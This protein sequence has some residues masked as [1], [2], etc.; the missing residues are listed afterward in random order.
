LR[1]PLLVLAFCLSAC[2][3]RG[4]LT[5]YPQAATVGK[6]ETIFVAS[7]RDFDPALGTYGT[8]RAETVTFSRFE[9]SI[10][11]VR[12]VGEIAWPKKDQTPDPETEFFT[13]SAVSF[14]GPTEFRADL[15]A[16]LRQKPAGQ[17]SATV[18]VHGFNNTFAEGLYRLAQLATDLDVPDSVIHYS[19]PSGA[20][21]LGYMYDRDS[22][23]FARDGF[24]KMLNEVIAA[25]P[26]DL[27]LACHSMGCQ[28]MMD[29]LR[30]MDIRNPGRVSREVDSVIMLSP[31]IDV[32]VFRSQALAISEL[33]DP[34]FIFSSQKDKA[35]RLASLLTGQPDRLG[36]LTN[37]EQVSDLKVTVL[38]TTNFSTGSG[39]LNVGESPA[40]IALLDKA[41]T[42]E[43]SL[44]RDRSGRPGLLP[45]VV[46]TA[47]TAT[48]I[49][50]SPVVAFDKEFNN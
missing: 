39:H 32:T 15:A 34:F 49:I 31:D 6:N 8:K 21:P 46:L 38:D 2:T 3:P 18:F 27:V 20:Q 11:P 17:R 4:E 14:P 19:W 25:S 47:R 33:P 26:D 44:D 41:G 50:V 29:A 10:P 1:K 45:G 13:T 43:D 35:L 42:I 23:L 36:N 48:A 12:E 37:L 40:L 22:V 24:E 30:Q 5:L 28:L 16:T 9:I 7:S